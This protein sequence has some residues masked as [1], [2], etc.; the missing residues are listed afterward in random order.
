MQKPEKKTLE[1]LD[2]QA[3]VGQSCVSVNVSVLVSDC[4]G[5]EERRCGV[6]TLKS[7]KKPT[8]IRVF[9]YR[10]LSTNIT[11]IT[12]KQTVLLHLFH[13]KSPRNNYTQNN[14][15]ITPINANITNHNNIKTNPITANKSK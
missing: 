9:K 4:V 1:P 11:I 12:T 3:T 2:L 6:V 7:L 13:E 14:A 15:V 5:S 8:F 10:S